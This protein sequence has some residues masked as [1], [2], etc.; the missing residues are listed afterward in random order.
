MKSTDDICCVYRYESMQG[1][2]E[3]FRSYCC[4]KA[5]EIDEIKDEVVHSPALILEISI[6]WRWWFLKELRGTLMKQYI[7]S[8]TP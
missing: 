7:G 8:Q 1:A 2:L 5:E 3:E 4:G 6:T